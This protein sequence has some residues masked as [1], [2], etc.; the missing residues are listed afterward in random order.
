M[1]ST[2]IAV[3]QVCTDA[4]ILARVTVA[5]LLPG[6]TRLR[7]DLLHAPLLLLEVFLSDLH[8]VDH[9]VLDAADERRRVVGQDLLVADDAADK[10]VEEDGVIVAGRVDRL[11]GLELVVD[12]EGQVRRVDGDVGLLP[13]GVV[14]VLADDDALVLGDQ[15]GVQ[16]EPSVP[17][18]EAEV[19]VA[20]PD[21]HQ[22]VADGGLELH[23]ELVT[24]GPEVKVLSTLFSIPSEIV[25]GT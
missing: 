9:D 21:G 1:A 7:V 17:E 3:P 5:L 13:P 12:A 11:C 4:V 24:L 14:Q 23:V 22:S 8:L 2:L 15:V 16:V 6:A 25:I 18:L 20:L 10:G 19:S